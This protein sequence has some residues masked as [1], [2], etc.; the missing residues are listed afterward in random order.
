M[1]IL[2][3]ER[4]IQVHENQGAYIDVNIIEND[5]D[6]IYGLLCYLDGY[7][8]ATSS[9]FFLTDS[10]NFFV[11]GGIE[12]NSPLSN[13]FIPQNKLMK[14]EIKEIIESFRWAY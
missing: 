5:H 3:F 7:S 11:S 8:I 9:Q 2:H 13:D 6:N 14:E 10:N 1:E 4:E 12:L